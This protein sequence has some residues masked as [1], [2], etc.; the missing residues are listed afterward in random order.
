MAILQTS[1]REGLNYEK[2]SDLQSPLA[3]WGA[4]RMAHLAPSHSM[5]HAISS[6]FFV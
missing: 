2:F 5:H 6:N 3:S 4:R 1:R